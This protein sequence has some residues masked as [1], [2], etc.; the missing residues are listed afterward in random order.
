M[1]PTPIA[2][3]TPSSE[4]PDVDHPNR[5]SVTAAN[6]LAQLLA[7]DRGAEILVEMQKLEVDRAASES[8][9][10]SP[11]A[12]SD[13]GDPDGAPVVGAWRAL[14]KPDGIALERRS[15]LTEPWWWGS[16]ETFPPPGDACR[17]ALLVG[18]S[19][20][21][22]WLLDPGFN[23][24]GVLGKILAASGAPPHQCVDLARSNADV[25]TLGEMLRSLPAIRPDVV[26]LF[27]GNNFAF[28]PLAD[29]YRDDLADALRQGGYAGMHRCYIDDVVMPR[30]ERLL[31]E[32][33]PLQERG[34]RV[35]VVVPQTNVRGWVP[36]PNIEV[37][38]LDGVAL[39]EWYELR[40][41]VEQAKA[42]GDWS[43]AAAAAER[44]S[45]LDQ[46]L[47]PVS[48]YAQGL[49]MEGLGRGAEAGR[50][51]EAARDAGAGL[52]VEHVPGVLVEVR[53]FLR[54]FARE[55][56]IPSV[57][58]GA[59]VGRRELPGVPDPRYFLDNC[60]LTD[61]GIELVM[62]EVAHA[63]CPRSDA[64]EVDVARA[65]ARVRA[66]AHAMAAAFCALRD[67]PEDIVRKQLDLA[68]TADREVCEEFL[69]RL[70]DLIESPGPR[71]IRP[72]LGQ[73]LE[74][75][76]A[77]HLTA[78]IA[79]TRNHSCGVWV[80]REVVR[81]VL[82]D[83]RATGRCDW[84]RI[85]LL[86]VPDRRR[87][88]SPNFAPA[89][90]FSESTGKRSRLA[91]A[92]ESLADAELRLTYRIPASV[93]SA[94]SAAVTVNGLPIGQL[95]DVGHW[96]TATLPVPGQA[97]R[98][99]VNWVTID[100]PVPACDATAA[101]ASDAALL[102]QRRFPEVLPVFGALFDAFLQARDVE[103]APFA[104]V[105]SRAE[106]SVGLHVARA[107]AE[108]REAAQASL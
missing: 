11:D 16:V 99:G 62:R 100:W 81:S 69:D 5:V 61:V 92:L 89:K 39:R 10:V 52:L 84:G 20:A 83:A 40:A 76:Q 24:A 79:Q 15:D 86:A 106:A 96:S 1:R 102:D 95:D 33:I 54:T 21:R 49:A 77:L 58:V 90:A 55:N 93:D 41:T 71:W 45:E 8:A 27:A 103:H 28:T 22:G 82:D 57:D 43:A 17:V 60:H 68:L 94:A 48:L 44:M 97:L 9:L 38:S 105:A 4:E 65:P 53:E 13:G 26:V 91:F 18:E 47:S 67:Q 63:I 101:V 50:F 7:D 29:A 46:G 23:P 98:Q 42:R 19:V 37:P 108:H 3:C 59:I 32:L 2:T 80:L 75:P 6:R 31:A 51:L 78:H 12:H 56:G 36:S 107:D 104:R 25:E 72:A 34:V 73:L 14:T 70:L 87:F 35:V 85:D 30:V 66:R 64:R 74:E 88:H